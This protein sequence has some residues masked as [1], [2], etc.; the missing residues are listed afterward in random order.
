MDLSDPHVCPGSGDLGDWRACPACSRPITARHTSLGLQLPRHHL[1]HG[2]TREEADRR[3]ADT[4]AAI[5]RCQEYLYRTY[6]Q[7]RP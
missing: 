1:P 3:I 7:R 2:V 6:H 5:A 4:R